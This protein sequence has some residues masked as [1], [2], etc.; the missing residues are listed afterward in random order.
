MA[1]VSE[2]ARLAFRGYTLQGH[3]RRDVPPLVSVEAE[4][5]RRA[6]LT[7]LPYFLMTRERRQSRSDLTVLHKSRP[8]D[9]TRF[10]EC[11]QIRK[12][13]IQTVLKVGTTPTRAPC[14]LSSCAEM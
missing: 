4:P 13:N 10:E 6:C 14:G 9:L 12:R 1:C 5:Q 3:W 2:E 7:E 11:Q 8:R